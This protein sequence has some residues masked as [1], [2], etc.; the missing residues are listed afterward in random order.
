MGQV[1]P[2]NQDSQMGK[3][4][5]IKTCY[6]VGFYVCDVYYSW[7]MQVYTMLL[8]AEK[9]IDKDTQARSTEV[10]VCVCVVQI[11]LRYVFGFCS[12]APLRYSLPFL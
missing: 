12:W 11:V 4:Y 10:C 9:D 5:R 1:S 6:D 7:S 2:S 3:Q 8:S